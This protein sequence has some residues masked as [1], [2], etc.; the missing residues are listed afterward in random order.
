MV[1]SYIPF[2]LLYV[3]Y[4][5]CL[6]WCD[7]KFWNKTSKDGANEKYLIVYTDNFVSFHYGR[8]ELNCKLSV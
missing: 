3:H 1:L 5:L 6:T 7:L 4:L 8:I 2:Y